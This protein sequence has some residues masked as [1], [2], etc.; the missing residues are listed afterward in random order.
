MRVASLKP[1]YT[2]P[3]SWFFQA[4]MSFGVMDLPNLSGYFIKRKGG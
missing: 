4:I 3:G 2:P 1:I